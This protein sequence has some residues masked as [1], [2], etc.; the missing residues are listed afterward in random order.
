[1]SNIVGTYIDPRN[2]PTANTTITISPEGVINGNTMYPITETKTAA[3]PST[4]PNLPSTLHTDVYS[5]SYLAAIPNQPGSYLLYKFPDLVNPLA[6]LSLSGNTLTVSVGS[7]EFP[8]QKISA[9]VANSS[10]PPVYLSTVIT[11]AL[12]TTQATRLP[13][14]QGTFQQTVPANA[15]LV[16]IN[17]FNSAQPVPSTVTM[18]PVI[19]TNPPAVTGMRV[20]EPQHTRIKCHRGKKHP[21]RKR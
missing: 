5:G 15:M 1:M 7:N 13:V 14:V 10:P 8:L 20:E 19:Q 17:F 6:T 9:A 21:K 18:Q 3:T 16:P 4:N 12:Q 2:T 11:P